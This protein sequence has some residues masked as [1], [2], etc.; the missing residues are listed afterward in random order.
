MRPDFAL[1]RVDDG[2]GVA[3]RQVVV[4]EHGHENDPFPDE[5]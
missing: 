2:P 4:E 3:V 1:A 5:A